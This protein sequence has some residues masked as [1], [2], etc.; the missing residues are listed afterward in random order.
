[1]V[2][3]PGH[4]QGG[5]RLIDLGHLNQAAPGDFATH[6]SGVWENAPWVAGCVAGLRPFAT[7]AELHEAMMAAVRGAPDAVRLAFLNGHPELG[8]DKVELTGESRAEQEALGL[9][10]TDVLAELN[11]AYRERFGIPFI[12][13]VRRHTPANILRVLRTRLGS[14][15]AAEHETALAEVGRIT[16][17]RLLDRVDGPGRPELAGR[18]TTHVLDTAAGCPAAGVEVE[19]WCEG[20]P[21]AAARTNADGRLPTPLLPPG[22]VRMGRYELRFGIGAYFGARGARSFYD[23]VPVAFAVDA[24]EGHY[25][26]PLVA[27]PWSYSTYRGS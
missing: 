26:V 4:G 7:V 23:V 27:S 12:V 11:T 14:D 9:D 17:L 20:R 22:P 24:A 1:M 5:R 6:L 10:A 21:V 19:L 3:A 16:R 25:H 18:L 8:A 2:A 15:M 13:C